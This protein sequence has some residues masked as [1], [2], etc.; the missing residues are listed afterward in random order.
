MLFRWLSAILLALS[1]V[2]CGSVH[3]REQVKISDTHW[4]AD[5][6]R[7]FVDS[8]ELPG[9]ICVF[10]NNG[11]HV[12]TSFEHTS[13]HGLQAPAQFRL[14]QRRTT[15]KRI[16]SIFA[17]TVGP[18]DVAQAG[19]MVEGMIAD[20]LHLIAQLHRFKAGTVLEGIVVDS[21]DAITDGGRV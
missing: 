8:G 12:V 6:L 17:N 1:V 21:L 7:P 5:A 14:C 2:G 20:G 9:A 11:V 16:T 18:V 19:T 4:G 3:S 10:Y 13:F 15:V